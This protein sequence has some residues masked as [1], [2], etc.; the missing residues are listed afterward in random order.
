[1]A[2]KKI[3]DRLKNYLAKKAKIRESN[4]I[5]ESHKHIALDLGTSREVI[6]RITKKLHESNI[7]I[8]HNRHIEL[9]NI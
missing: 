6:S 4:T 1:M 9:L 8:Q 3:E 7:L 2:F 5:V